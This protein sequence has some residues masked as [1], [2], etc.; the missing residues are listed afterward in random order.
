MQAVELASRI[1]YASSS[2]E[3]HSW[4]PM[5]ALADSLSLSERN[6]LVECC[7][8][9][10]APTDSPLPVVHEDVDSQLS[11]LTRIH[12]VLKRLMS[13]D[14]DFGVNQ[15]KLDRGVVLNGIQLL[16]PGDVPVKEKE[17][18]CSERSCLKKHF[19][20]SQNVLAEAWKACDATT[21]ISILQI[22]NSRCLKLI[23]IL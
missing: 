13:F 23:H 5:R 11:P 19:V 8:H 15:V 6:F 21:G 22:G 3:S 12:E 14:H 4:T 16:K 1:L 2:I 17:C 18:S 20:N 10:K 9:P 7:V